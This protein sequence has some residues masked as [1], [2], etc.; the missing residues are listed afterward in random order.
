MFLLSSALAA[1]LLVYAPDGSVRAGEPG[2]I[3]VYCLGCSAPL[4]LGALTVTGAPVLRGAV[5]V[6]G[7]LVVELGVPTAEGLDLVATVAEG[8]LR[9]RLE[10]APLRR[11]GL[12]LTAPAEVP[13]ASSSVE[14]RL[15]GLDPTHA[16]GVM[17]R[18]SEGTVG[19]LRVTP[20]GLAAT[21][22][23]GSE[24]AARPLLLA[25]LDLSDPHAPPALAVVRLRARHTGS[26]AAEAGTR[27]SIR[28]GGR[29]YGP[30][31]AGAEGTAAVAFDALPGEPT[32]ELTVSDDLGNTQK[33]TQP[34]PAVTEPTVLVVEDGRSDAPQLWLSAA[35]ER[36]FP[37][38]GAAPVCRSGATAPEAAIPVGAA[39]WRWRPGSSPGVMGEVATACVLGTVQ[40]HIRLAVGVRAPEAIALRFYPDVLSADFPLAEVLA[41][42]ID[43]SGER[44]G[45]EGLDLSAAH[46]KMVVHR[47]DDALR[48]EYDGTAAAALG[49]DVVHARWT[50]RRGV[51]APRA[52]SL[53]AARAEAGLFAVVRVVDGRGDPLPDVGVRVTAGGAALRE[54]PSDARGF[55]RWLLPPSSGPIRLRAEG[56]GAAAE[57]LAIPDQPGD[58]GCLTRADPAAADL[59]AR[60][61][62]P[63]RS[64]RVR[65]VFL[66]V[67]PRTVTLGPGATAE[68]R[69]RMLDGAGGLVRDEPL[70]LTASE[71]TVTLPVATADGTFVARFDPGPHPG[72]RDVTITATSAAGTVATSL[73]VA[74]RPVRG[75][76]AA[77][78][79]WVGNFGSISSPTGS[80]SVERRLPVGGLSARV[81]LGVY[82]LSETVQAGSGSVHIVGSFFPIDA[83]VSFAQ[84]GPRFSLSA[85]I[86]LA[87]VPYALEADFD[88]EDAVSGAG[89]GSPGVDVRGSFGWRI[90]QTEI[91]AEGGY[92]LF[93]VPDGAVTLAQNAGGL[94]AIVGYRLLY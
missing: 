73:S 46:G 59:D 41:T 27:L 56:G 30:F 55:A 60:I 72:A 5:G 68:I 89:L 20:A 45:V 64:G 54:V 21:V 81:G 28:I 65:Q 69:V 94:R 12:V 9:T 31:V 35:D 2:R 87:L 18:A 32:Y 90:G 48:A 88:G 43:Q 22:T 33:L 40:R 52:M 50:R 44:V 8:A 63:I 61:R 49:E 7:A 34:V 15:T 62:V 80:V 25:A 76:V 26:V 82:G 92:L 75:L 84:R 4:A 36:A 71:G 58:P 85:G 79:G 51:G 14:V 3:G 86:S 67:E 23:L 77:G 17:V 70:A 66:D 47:S 10:V 74:P 13:L 11:S 6:D 1:E 91:Y 16:E 24:R 93:T 78:F 19:P 57:A 42:L 39:Q 37:W 29:T 83:G 53:C 38:T